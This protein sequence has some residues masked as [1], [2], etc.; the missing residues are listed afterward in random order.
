MYAAVGIQPDARAAGVGG[1]REGKG[2]AVETL[3]EAP[4]R[5]LRMPMLCRLSHRTSICGKAPASAVRANRSAHCAPQSLASLRLPLVAPPPPG[6]DGS[7]FLSR[8]LGP[9][10]SRNTHASLPQ[11]RLNANMRSRADSRPLS[12]K[13][14]YELHGR[15]HMWVSVDMHVLNCD[16]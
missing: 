16:L 11:G 14:A 1:G 2:R 9:A 3:A 15:V 6:C 8:W 4:S 13:R 7:T 10:S 5:R 12:S